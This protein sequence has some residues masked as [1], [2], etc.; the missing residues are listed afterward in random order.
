MPTTLDVPTEIV[1]DS[2]RA[3][4]MIELQHHPRVHSH[5]NNTVKVPHH[6]GAGGDTTEREAV[7]VLHPT[8]HRNSTA[9]AEQLT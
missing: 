7:N 4:T 9:V 6:N 8:A 3:P 5:A 2:Y 1:L